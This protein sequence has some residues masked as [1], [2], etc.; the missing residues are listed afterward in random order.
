MNYF[1]YKFLYWFRGV[2]LCNQF[3]IYKLYILEMKECHKR[4]TRH[5]LELQSAFISLRAIHANKPNRKLASVLARIEEVLK[6]MEGHARG[7]RIK[8]IR[9]EEALFTKH[10]V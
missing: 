6:Y 9:I 1:I 10:S 4:L 5:F 2:V 8:I 7:I 3:Y